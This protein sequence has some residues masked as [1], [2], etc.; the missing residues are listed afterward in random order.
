MTQDM[1]AANH[2]IDAAQFRHVAGHLASGVTVITTTV[3]GV[4]FGMTASSVTSLSV[5][6]PMMLACLNEAVPTTGA[7]ARAG[8]FVINVLGQGHEDIAYQFA[9][10][11][12]DKFSGL[13]VD[14]GPDGKPR[15]RDALAHL[16]CEVSEQ[17]AGGTHTVFIA[18]VREASASDGRPLTYFR[19]GFGRFEFERNDAAYEQVRTMVLQRVFAANDVLTVE[20]LANE[21]DVDRSTSFYAL[22]RLAADGLVRRDPDLGYVV[23]SFDV[24]TSDETFDARLAVELGVIDLCAGH[25]TDAELA[26]LR[27]RFDT[28]ADQLVGDRFVDFYAY[29]DANYAFHEYLVSLTHNPLLITTFGKLS[30]KSVMTR[31]FGATPES[32]H[33]FIDAQRELVE[34]LEAGDR[35]AASTAARRY[36]ELAK[37]RVR[38]ILDLTGG[39]L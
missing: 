21:L 10:P 14:R 20:E 15:L 6:P 29:L 1:T 13:A 7:V 35:E 2:S 33:E 36:C 38:D 39:R 37:Q 16:V 9:S 12:D 4:D 32:S 18:H 25:V 34:G 19:G 3:D 28:M 26:E 8:H 5:D 22:T 31:S 23:T 17:V 27:S 24:R 30:I 11:R